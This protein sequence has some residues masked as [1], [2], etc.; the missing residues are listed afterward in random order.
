MPI[1]FEQSAAEVARLVK[2]FQT[3]A[4]S[5]HPR[6]TRKRRRART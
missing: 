6:I 3:N 4:G 1:T 5:F 2:Y